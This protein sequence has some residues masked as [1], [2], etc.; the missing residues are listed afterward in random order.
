[1]KAAAYVA[2]LAVRDAERRVR[3]LNDELADANTAL[4]AA[5]GQLSKIRRGIR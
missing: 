1:M 3:Q 5:K 4:K 2:E